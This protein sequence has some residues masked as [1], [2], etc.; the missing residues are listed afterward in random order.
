MAKN[1]YQTYT[2]ET[3]IDTYRADFIR[4]SAMCAALAARYPALLA[5][6]TEADAILGQIDSRRAAL[7]QA[8]DDQIRARAVEDVAKLDV[9]DVYTELRRMMAAKNRNVMS[10]LPDA[11]SMLGRLGAKTFGERADQAVANLKALP[12]GDELKTMLLPKLEKELAEFHQADIAEDKTRADLQSTRMALV[13]YKTELSQA[14]EGQLGALQKVFGDRE[15]TAQFTIPWR[16][17]SKPAADES[18]PAPE[19]PPVA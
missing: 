7:Q 19:A 5:V 12:D 18:E 3:P 13:L 10:L 2:D 16:K 14:R 6:G 1:T 9:I 15:K 17:V 8:E 11:P 4:R